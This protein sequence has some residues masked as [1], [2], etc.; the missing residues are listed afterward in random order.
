MSPKFCWAEH[1]CFSGKSKIVSLLRRGCRRNLTQSA[2]K[3]LGGHKTDPEQRGFTKALSELGKAVAVA[4]PA[5]NSVSPGHLI[6][7]KMPEELGWLVRGHPTLAELGSSC[8]CLWPALGLW[9]RFSSGDGHGSRT[10]FFHFFVA[11]G[12][13][14]NALGS[15]VIPAEPDPSQAAPSSAGLLLPALAEHW[16]TSKAMPLP[17][18][19][20]QQLCC[21]DLSYR[22]YWGSRFLPQHFCEQLFLE[23]SWSH[24]PSCRRLLTF[25]ELLLAADGFNSVNVPPPSLCLCLSL[26][27]VSYYPS[28]G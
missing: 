9:Q 21:A 2:A 28:A 13:F 3:Y 8:T 4:E 16:E 18:A 15:S 11:Q 12:I 24:L 7:S 26:C 27:G 25:M 6:T 1:S 19:N 22:H 20:W 5:N 14:G 17:G 10:G 23:T